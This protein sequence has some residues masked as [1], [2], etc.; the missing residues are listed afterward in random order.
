MPVVFTFLKDS[1]QNFNI[2][3]ISHIEGN[4]YLVSFCKENLELGQHC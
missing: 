3:V 1:L 2:I 4:L